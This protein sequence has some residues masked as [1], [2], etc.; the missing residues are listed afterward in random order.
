M[1]LSRGCY[2]KRHRCPGWAGGGMKY[3]EKNLC[4]DGRLV[5]NYDARLWRWRFHRCDS[6]DVLVLPDI[7]RWISPRWLRVTI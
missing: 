6:C 2:D 7:L 3:A 4:D 5:I 1:R